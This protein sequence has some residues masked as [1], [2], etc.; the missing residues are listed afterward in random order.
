MFSYGEK[1]REKERG[2]I[3]LES[4]VNKFDFVNNSSQVALLPRGMRVAVDLEVRGPAAVDDRRQP[5][6]G[7]GARPFTEQF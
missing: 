2:Q 7:A 5:A 3:S 6:G 1:Q 4:K